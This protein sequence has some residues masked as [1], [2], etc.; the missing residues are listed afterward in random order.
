MSRFSALSGVMY[1][2]EMPFVS[3]ADLFS[4][5]MLKMGKIDA[6]VLPVPVGAI[7]STFLP[8]RIGG[9]AMRWMSLGSSRP[10]LSR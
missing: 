8:S 6:R 7:T 3:L 4:K 10:I 1:S 9:I 2:I 5:N